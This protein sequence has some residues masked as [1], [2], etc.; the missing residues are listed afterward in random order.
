MKYITLI[1]LF[2]LVYSCRTVVLVD[3][4]RITKRQERK[5]FEKAFNES[6]GQMTEEEV[7]LF[8]DVSLAVDTSERV[9][10]A[11]TDTSYVIEPLLILYKQ[12]VPSVGD[13]S[14]TYIDDL[15]IVDSVKYVSFEEHIWVNYK[16]IE[17]YE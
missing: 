11:Y 15:S 3:G 1:L 14:I 7:A 12:L 13:T 5:I 6:F 2:F 4:T 16:I 8:E 9:I 17:V 10:M